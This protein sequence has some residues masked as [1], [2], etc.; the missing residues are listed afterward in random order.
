MALR[1]YIPRLI[2]SVLQK[3][4]RQF[5][6][7]GLTGPRQSG[8]STTLQH[9]FTPQFKYVSFD[10]TTVREQ[11]IADPELFLDELGKRVIF[12]EIQYVPTLLSHLKL[13]VDRNRDQR[14]QYLLTGSQQFQL[15]K[16]LSETLAGRI[17]L[18]NLLPLSTTEQLA[19]GGSKPHL[20]D[21]TA[22]FVRQ[23]LRG[24]FPELIA[25]PRLDPTT[26]YENYIQTYLEKD[27]RGLHNIGN[28]R[29]FR[30][31]M[32]LAASRTAQLFNMSLFARDV[33]V[34]VP[35]I[36][37]WTSVLESSFIVY[38]LPPYHHH[39]GKRITKSPKL[40]FL[41]IGLASHLVGL[42]TREHL[43]QSPM[44]GALFETY[45]LQETVK[46]FM[47]L[48]RFPRLYYWRSASGL[49]IDLLIEANGVLYP[50]EGKLTKT[51]RRAMAFPLEE[52]IAI[53]ARK[54]SLGTAQ[55]VSLTPGTFSLTRQVQAI[56]LLDYLAKP[57]FPVT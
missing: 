49:E 32:A 20:P 45:L 31:F 10:H 47:N 54:S 27:V 57:P 15:M 46:H 42:K 9:L 56:N 44:A 1:R 52:F 53:S 23:S 55:L 33:G 30:R 8:K 2:E 21:A 34:S 51:V 36:R 39:F 22:Q 26:W 4:L 13:R 14:G 37:T 25:H 18:L 5:P 38:L 28:L 17:G 19:A 6:V 11:A 40:Y 3:R 16:N 50:A 7:V 12:D 43:L 29:D 41:D 48:G 35:T 24:S